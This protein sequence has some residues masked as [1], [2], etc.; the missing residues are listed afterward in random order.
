M[1]FLNH[2]LFVSSLKVSAISDDI[3]WNL[4]QNATNFYYIKKK[5]AANKQ[6]FAVF[7][8][9]GDLY[10]SRNANRSTETDAAKL[11]LIW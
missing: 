1:R 6:I 7:E 4:W 2:W 10:C 3:R 5:L 9:S 11:I 8:V